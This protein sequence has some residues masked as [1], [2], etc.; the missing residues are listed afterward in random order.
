MKKFEVAKA[1]E[2]LRKKRDDQTEQ[3]GAKQQALDATIA[4]M[5]EEGN[6]MDKNT[7]IAQQHINKNTKG[8][9]DNIGIREIVITTADALMDV[10]HMNGKVKTEKQAN[11]RLS[12]AANNVTATAD[13]KAEA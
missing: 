5:N 13:M 4:K 9:E 12:K 1:I 8:L 7:V 11:T 6:E 3:R 2:M 10:K